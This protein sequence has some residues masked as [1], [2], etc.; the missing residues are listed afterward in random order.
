MNHQLH[1]AWA[2]LNESRA[3]RLRMSH[4]PHQVAFSWTLLNWAA[5]ARRRYMA[6]KAAAKPVQSDLFGVSA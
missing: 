1:M 6:E 3:R 4:L 2:H 5:S